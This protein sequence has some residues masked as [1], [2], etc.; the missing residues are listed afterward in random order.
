MSKRRKGARAE[1]RLNS[2]GSPLV[3]FP[4]LGP[5]EAPS[6]PHLIPDA[7]EHQFPTPQQKSEGECGRTCL[8]AIAQFHHLDIS[9]DDIEAAVPVTA[10]G[11]S[12]YTLV[13]GARRLGFRASAWRG[14]ADDLAMAPVPAI[15]HL[16]YAGALHYVVLVRAMPNHA[17][18]MDPALGALRT[19]GSQVI[20]ERWSGHILLLAPRHVAFRLAKRTAHALRRLLDHGVFKGEESLTR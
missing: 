6:S 8:L 14:T 13:H 16:Q 12:L 9:C 4:P 7:D 15:L 5:A 19:V 1:S 10:S 20:E 18:L 11:V 2:G 3:T 17:L